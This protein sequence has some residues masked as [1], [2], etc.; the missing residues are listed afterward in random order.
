MDLKDSL[1][2]NS[3]LHTLQVLDT[4]TS[5]KIICHV[6]KL[7]LICIKMLCRCMKKKLELHFEQQ[8]NH[9]HKNATPM[10]K[11]VRNGI[12]TLHSEQETTEQASDL[13]PYL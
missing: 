6:L 7:I 13:F 10:S 1:D 3:S 8:M 11:E 12:S 4:G 9:L 5:D 2:R